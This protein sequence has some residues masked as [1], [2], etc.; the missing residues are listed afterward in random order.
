MRKSSF[1]LLLATTLA[2]SSCGN[3]DAPVPAQPAAPTSGPLKVLTPFANQT[4]KSLGSDGTIVFSVPDAL[5]LRG[6]KLSATQVD[7]VQ[8]L[9]SGTILASAPTPAAPYGLLR[10]VTDVEVAGDTIRVE[11]APATLEDALNSGAIQPGEYHLTQQVN[12]SRPIYAQQVLSAQGAQSGN[13]FYNIPLPQTDLGPQATWT[14]GTGQE[15]CLPVPLPVSAQSPIQVSTDLRACYQFRNSLTIDLKI[16]QVPVEGKTTKRLA[17]TYFTVR[18]DGENNA[19][20]RSATGLTL[21]AETPVSLPLVSVGYAPL[22]FMLGPLPVVV[23]PAYRLGFDLSGQ[24]KVDQPFSIGVAQHMALGAEYVRPEWNK[25]DTFAVEPQITPNLTGSIAAKARFTNDA[26][27]IFYGIAGPE[28]GIN[29]YVKVAY[30]FGQSGNV[31]LGADGY[32]GIKAGFP[33][34]FLN[35]RYNWQKESVVKEF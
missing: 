32:V 27:V 10:R 35:Y 34:E 6:Q 4:I 5:P 33:F 9:T 11:T 26:S 13:G 12:T 31:A 19:T 14:V 23:T 16:E 25:L 30:T 24:V 21:S 15:K 22:V 20:M 18:V 29:P 7:D 1:G 3:T 2:L 28:L 8:S 17:V